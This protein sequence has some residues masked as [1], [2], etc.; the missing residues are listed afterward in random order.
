MSFLLLACAKPL[1][2]KF[3]VNGE[4]EKLSDSYRLK[5]NE[6][7]GKLFHFVRG[8]EDV[9][10]GK[11]GPLWAIPG[12]HIDFG[13]VRVEV[14][15]DELRLYAVGEPNVR[16]GYERI[17][18]S[19]KVLDNYD[20]EKDVNDFGE[21]TNRTV[22]KRDRPWNQRQYVYVDWGNLLNKNGKITTQLHFYLEL[23][24]ENTRQIGGISRDKGYI[25]FLTESRVY[26]TFTSSFTD[27]IQ[28]KFRTHLMPYKG[29]A[30]FKVHEY[31]FEDFKKFGYFL[32]Y[33][34]YNHPEKG[35]LDSTQRKMAKIFNICEPK[36]NR[37]C[38]TNQI[39]YVL[40][41]GFPDRYLSLAQR[42]VNEWNEVFQK[43]L[44]RKDDVV[45]LDINDRRDISDP[46]VNMIALFDHDVPSAIDIMGVSQTVGNSKTGE[47]VSA[48]ATVY[49]Q[50]LRR[51]RG[52]IDFFIDL[53]LQKYGNW[54][55]PSFSY[56]LGEKISAEDFLN[57]ANTMRKNLAFSPVITDY[58]HSLG[59][60]ELVSIA[61]D[62]AEEVQS[63]GDPLSQKKRF[64]KNYPEF[65]SLPD[66]DY[67][68]LTKNEDGIFL[69]EKGHPYNSFLG[70]EGLHILAQDE[71][72]YAGVDRQQR[73]QLKEMGFLKKRNI[74]MMYMGIHTSEFVDEAILRYI[75]KYIQKHGI[76]SLKKSR[77][78][79]KD[80][81][82]HE[83][84]YSTLLHELGHNFG[85]RHNFHGSADKKHY[86]SEY[87][88]TLE[89]LQRREKGVH[90]L[91]LDTMAYSSIMDYESSFYSHAAGLGPYDSAA[92]KYGYL[93][94]IDKKSDPIVNA[95]FMFCTDH[96]IGEDILCNRFDQGSTV[97]EITWSLIDRYKKSYLRTHFRNDRLNYERFLGKTVNS[98]M[99]RY[100][101]PIRRVIDEFMFKMYK[102]NFNFIKNSIQAGE[103]I[104]L[105]DPIET[106]KSGLIFSDMST[107]YKS[108]IKD[109]N[110]L[111][112]P[113]FYIPGGLADLIFANEL[114]LNFF[115]EILGTPEPGLF[116]AEKLKDGTNQLTRLGLGKGV[117]QQLFNLA[118]R[119]GIEDIDSFI[120][121]HRTRLVQLDSGPLAKILS[122]QYD[123]VFERLQSIGYIYDKIIAEIALGIRDLGIFKYNR[124]NFNGNAYLWPISSKIV[125]GLFNKLITQDPRISSINI[126]TS[127][128]KREEYF[129]QAGLSSN[130]KIQ[131][132]VIGLIDF[133]NHENSSFAD[134]MR[135]CDLVDKDRCIDSGYGSVEFV[136]SSGQGLFK[137][138]QT[139]SSDSIA[140]TLVSK[141]VDLSKTHADLLDKIKNRDKY[142]AEQYINLKEVEKMNKQLESAIDATI[143]L[144]INFGISFK[145]DLEKIKKYLISK[146][147]EEKSAWLM[148]NIA[149]ETLDKSKPLGFSEYIQYIKKQY[150]ESYKVID[151]LKRKDISMTGS[152]PITIEMYRDSLEDV[153][154]SMKKSEEMILK[155]ISETSEVLLAPYLIDNVERSMHR[156]EGDLTFIRQIMENLNLN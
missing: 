12:F 65:F 57:Q 125:L 88:K 17:V 1:H 61:E 154:K 140:Y 121:S 69:K 79:I 31:T 143:A 13:L 100:M 141:G 5:R 89:R 85:L 106:E 43:Q 18:A 27:P 147:E 7:D 136:T 15:K 117:E 52:E 20:V 3:V 128:G 123:S 19:Y 146:K 97:S 93:S 58:S 107:L 78:L 109:K 99:F 148:A 102:E 134:K 86:T 135:V 70:L 87:Y 142:I 113:S 132:I 47:I 35:P 6:L 96:Q 133:V 94:S 4:L 32:M 150:F 126:A 9:G 64:M 72:P 44:G 119:R 48:R 116:V 39:K 103:V 152:L 73:S 149:M 105:N 137:A 46:R 145:A 84:F 76:A 156:I 112:N 38:S 51:R 53:I 16:P 45:I 40:N 54:M 91:D 110:Y 90:P 129:V 98:L 115:V 83:V 66:S 111:I 155:P 127:D 2:H 63:I 11:G 75:E 28:V 14:L 33:E 67:I 80:H 77:K 24:E 55:S 74:N 49:G 10:G 37:S 62:V 118:Q 22:I 92:I 36:T 124:A 81:I 34:N 23:K 114:A 26:D 151:K 68:L 130:T 42:A 139:R 120:Y 138:A 41:K 122:S 101:L 131:A 60:R 59:V 82:E 95:N 8:V 104:D 56:T 144:E 71:T 153:L 50:G 29:S 30:D 21:K 25:S 108:L